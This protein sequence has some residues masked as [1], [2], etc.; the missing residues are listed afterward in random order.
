[1]YEE[2]VISRDSGTCTVFHQYAPPRP[3]LR[4]N[5]LQEIRM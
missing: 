3:Y 5:L 4:G 1:M 2:K